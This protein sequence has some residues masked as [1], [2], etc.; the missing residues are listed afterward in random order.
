MQVDVYTQPDS[1]FPIRVDA[2]PQL[3][4]DEARL[5]AHELLRAVRRLECSG[6]EANR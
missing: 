2:P 4:I 1:V 6:E 5:L 3:T